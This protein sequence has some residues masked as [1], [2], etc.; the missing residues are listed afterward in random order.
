MAYDSRLV[1]VV[2]TGY[3]PCKIC[4]GRHADNKTATGRDAKKAGVAVDKKFISLGSYLDIPGYTRGPNNNGSWIKADD[5]G[6]K[7]YIT[8][9]VIDVRFKTHREAKEWG[10]KA[11]KVR[12]WTKR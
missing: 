12:I 3:C 5:T 7:E 9:N 10:R 6:N 2:A 8:G 4:C 11:I 1:M